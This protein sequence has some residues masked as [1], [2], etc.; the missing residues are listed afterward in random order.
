MWRTRLPSSR[1]K[2]GGFGHPA[3]LT[4]V[5][6]RAATR[7]TSGAPAPPRA[8]AASPSP[9]GGTPPSSSQCPCRTVAPRC[10]S[11]SIAASRASARGGRAALGPPPVGQSP[12]RRQLPLK[13]ISRAPAQAAIAAQHRPRECAL[14]GERSIGAPASATGVGATNADPEPRPPR[15]T[16]GGGCATR[17][18]CRPAPARG[19]LGSSAAASMC[20]RAGCPGRDRARRPPLPTRARRHPARAVPAPA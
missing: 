8:S 16:P 5:G 9:L 13:P 20:A 10:H 11:S 17:A 3:N 2:R 4:R 6:G 7:A 19:V 14:I 18:T 1:E 15:V 12:S